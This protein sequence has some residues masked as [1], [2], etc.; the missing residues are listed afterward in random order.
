MFFEGVFANDQGG[1]EEMLIHILMATYNGK[2]YLAEQLGSIA[3]QTEK[4]WKLHIRD[5]CSEDGTWELLQDFAAK[6]PGQVE[7]K[8]NPKRLGAKRNFAR[9]LQEVQEPGDYAFCDQDDIWEPRKLST[10]QKRLREAERQE[11]FPGKHR[12]KTD[13]H[14]AEGE[15]VLPVLVYSDAIV[16]D[17]KGRM[18]VDSFVGQTGIELP[19]TR[20]MES[21]F[22]CNFVQ[23]AASMWNASLH[24]LLGRHPMPREALMQTRNRVI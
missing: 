1:D 14:L 21:L 17:G 23:G 6:F 18:L 20:A 8:R 12:K 7:L 16:I 13:R 19:K 9:L 10:L 5:D 11:R 2:K 15:G 4:G 24:K 3:A 22:L